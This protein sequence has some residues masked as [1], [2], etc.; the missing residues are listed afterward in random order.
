MEA[1]GLQP[2]A[3]TAHSYDLRSARRLDGVPPTD[4]RGTQATQESAPVPPRRKW[5]S[6]G[7]DLSAHLAA[8][9]PHHERISMDNGSWT[10]A[11]GL[12]M[13]AGYEG[14]SCCDPVY[15][16]HYI[17]PRAFGAAH[18]SA[19]EQL[20]RLSPLELFNVKRTLLLLRVTL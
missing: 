9:R 8:P 14:N 17:G 2:V 19:E 16:H 13:S 6:W 15:H 3:P 4:A 1:E 18:Q 20:G 11:H 10:G 7:L 5:Q 12:C